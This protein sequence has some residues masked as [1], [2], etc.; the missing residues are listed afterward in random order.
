MLGLC[1]IPWMARAHG[2]GQRFDLPLPLELYLYGSGATVALSFAIIA[3]FLRSRDRDHDLPTRPLPERLTQALAHPALIG[4]L[5]AAAVGIVA[6]AV[7]AGFWG[8]QD[9]AQNVLPTLVWIIWWTGMAYVCALCGD[10]WGL[11]NPWSVSF[12]WLEAIHGRL[13]PHGRIGLGLRYPEWLGVWPGL[14]AFVVFVWAELIWPDNAIPS[15][16]AWAVCAYSAFNW[17][18]MF[19]FGR[20]TWL[21][22][23]DAFAIAF[24]LFARFAPLEATPTLS[25][26]PYGAALLPDGPISTSLTAFVLVMLSTVTFD[27]LMAT[28]LWREVYTAIETWRPIMP[29]LFALYQQGLGADLSI[30]T[31]GL[32]AASL[33]FA[34]TYLVFAAL[35]AA[36]GNAAA[37]RGGAGRSAGWVARTFVLTLVPIAIAYHLAHYLGFLLTAGQLIIPLASDPFGAGWNLFGTADYRLNIGIIGARFV[38]YTSV[39]AI[40]LGHVIAVFL[41][42]VLAL[43]AFPDRRSALWSQVPV[44]VLMVAYTFAS[45]WILGQPITE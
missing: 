29:T 9:P 37:G 30:P 26:R 40:V 2:F 1:A 3:L 12:S 22:R 14:A 45:L 41:A 35:A 31:I 19:A 15:N 13:R 44:L 24:G 28:S 23:G 27:G 18:G 5:R 20:T 39:I 34:A 43:R 38:W 16:L 32:V 42:H 7:S 25:V 11:V 36:L 10:L 4:V 21:E 6:I 8:A 17:S 33:V